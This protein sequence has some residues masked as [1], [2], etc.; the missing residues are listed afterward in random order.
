MVIRLYLIEKTAVGGAEWNVKKTKIWIN[1]IVHMSLVLGKGYV[2]T[3]LPT[4]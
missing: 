4:I 2:V 1:A 3:A